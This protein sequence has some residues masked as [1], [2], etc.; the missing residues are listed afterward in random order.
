MHSWYGRQIWNHNLIAK[1]LLTKVILF[2]THYCQNGSYLEITFSRTLKTQL[3]KKSYVMS[4]TRP[5]I[6]MV[7]FI[8]K[9]LKYN[10]WY[11]RWWRGRISICSHY[12]KI[13]PNFIWDKLVGLKYILKSLN[14][15]PLSLIGVS[16]LPT[17]SLCSQSCRWRDY[18]KGSNF[19]TR[20]SFPCAVIL[21]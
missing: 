13:L 6:I 5:I 15:L 12:S 1:H 19:Q 20:R 4:I 3:W 21:S 18:H 9:A 16:K 11:I 17:G 7:N 10:I 14:G 8:E 2:E